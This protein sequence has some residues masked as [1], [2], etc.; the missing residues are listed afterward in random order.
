M[1]WAAFSGEI[2][3]LLYLLYSNNYKIIWNIKTDDA[4]VYMIKF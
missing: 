4:A 3:N 2:Q 1:S